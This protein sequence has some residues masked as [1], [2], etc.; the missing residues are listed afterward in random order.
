[1][2]DFWFKPLA[3]SYWVNSDGSVTEWKEPTPSSEELDWAQSVGPGIA[4]IRLTWSQWVVRHRM[5]GED[6][7]SWRLHDDEIGDPRA[8]VPLNPS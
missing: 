1:M 5:L 2:M 4:V 7:P 3:V 8:A 6:A